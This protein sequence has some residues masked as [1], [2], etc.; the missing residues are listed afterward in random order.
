L[1]DLAKAGD[2]DGVRNY[3]VKGSNSYSKMVARYRQDLLAVHAAWQATVPAARR[4]CRSAT[5]A[6]EHRFH[7]DDG[8]QRGARLTRGAGRRAT[9]RSRSTK[10]RSPNSRRNRKQGA[11]R[12]H[13]LAIASPP[14]LDLSAR[15]F[16]VSNRYCS[17][18][19][20]RR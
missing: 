1:F 11:G 3:E 20:H 14:M 13:A 8:R 9:R 4:R 10:A 5:V 19:A 18:A 17:G 6:V 15:S 16:S 7:A 2:R 12:S